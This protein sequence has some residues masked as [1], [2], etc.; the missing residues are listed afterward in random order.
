[1]KLVAKARWQS[2]AFRQ[3]VADCHDVRSAQ[4]RLWHAKRRRPITFKFQL[5]DG[6]II[7]GED[8]FDF[9]KL[10]ELDYARARR[11][12]SGELPVFSG[13]YYPGKAPKLRTLMFMNGITCHFSSTPEFCK[14]E[15][16]SVSAINGVFRGTHRHHKG[17]HLPE[18][19]YYRAQKLHI[20]NP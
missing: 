6:R 1:M 11:V 16:L 8:L 20:P 13:F 9:C 15:D 12:A 7:S 3:K 10:Q 19:D 17:W 4:A 18:F 5:L 14:S 2:E